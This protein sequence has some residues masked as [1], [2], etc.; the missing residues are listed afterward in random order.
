MESHY[1]PIRAGD[2]VR[3]LDPAE[4]AIRPPTQPAGLFVSEEQA[5]GRSKL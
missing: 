5:A 4:H 3:H 2:D 1:V